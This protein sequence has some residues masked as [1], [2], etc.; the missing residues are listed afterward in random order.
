VGQTLAEAY[1]A[2]GAQLSVVALKRDRFLMMN[3]ALEERIEARDV[4]VVIGPDDEIETF[5]E[6]GRA[7]IRP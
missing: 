4:L 2:C 7:E 3:P 6:A 5:A 1:A